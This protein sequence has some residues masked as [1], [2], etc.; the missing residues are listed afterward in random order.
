VALEREISIVLTI[1]YFIQFSRQATL[2]FRD[3][4]GTF[5]YDRYKPLIEGVINLIISIIFVQFWGVSGVLI[6]TILTNL[7]ICD[8]V[9]PWVLYKYAF[10][11]K[12]FKFYLTNYLFIVY[13]ILIV[14]GFESIPIYFSRPLYSLL[15]KGSLSVLIS[16]M[17]L[18][19]L[20]V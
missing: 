8:I 6:S 3:A 19:I 2:V 20:L 1:N 9:E 7:F 13:F 4:S 5:Y 18:S 10:N 12:P 11:K 14:I 16:I 17:S 15:T